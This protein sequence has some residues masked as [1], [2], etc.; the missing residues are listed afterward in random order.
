MALAGVF[1]ACTDDDL[2]G[3]SSSQSSTTGQERPAISDVTL[4]MDEAS[5]R[6]SYNGSFAFEEGDKISAL[7]MDENNTGVRY[8]STTDTDEWNALTWLERYHLVDYVH[9]NYPFIYDG[10]SFVADCN[11]LEG[12]Y[13]LVYPYTNLDGNRQA[14]IDIATQVQ[15]SGF[16]A[17]DSQGRGD[18]V[19]DN[20]Y[21]V[22][23][24]KLDAGQG[25]SD[26][27]ANLVPLLTP[28]RIAITSEGNVYTTYHITKLVFSHP[29]L[30]G[31]LTLDP[32]RA[33]YASTSGV[34][35]NLDAT[36]VNGHTESTNDVYHF[37]YA[38]FLGNQTST[39]T[40][41]DWEKELYYNANWGSTLATDYV[42]NIT[43]ETGSM[44]VARDSRDGSTYYW[45]DAIRATVQP[46]TEFNNTEYAT[47]YVEVYLDQDGAGSAA[48][49]PGGTVEAIVML[50]AFDLRNGNNTSQQDMILTIYM[51]EGIVQNINLSQ[52]YT[53][54]GT[55]LK[56][57]G[58]IDHA[59]PTDTSIQRVEFTIDN[60]AVVSSPTAVT[61]NN[62]NDLLQWLQWLNASSQNTGNKNPIATFTND[63]TIGDELA[64][65]IDLL[66]ANYV[67]TIKSGAVAGNNLR[68]ATANYPDLL[69]KLD[70]YS[71]V[72][73]EVMDGGVLNLSDTSYNIYHTYQANAADD[74]QGQLHIEVA[75]GGVLNIVGNDLNVVQGA[76][77]SSG[78]EISDRTEVFISNAG[79]LNVEEGISVVG[80]YITNE[81]EINV[82]EGASLYFTSSNGN[83]SVNTIKGFINVEGMISGTTNY[84]F[85]NFGT[86]NNGSSDGTVGGT[87]YN[88]INSSN[89]DNKIPGQIIIWSTESF[90]NLHSNTGLVDYQD[91]LA[92]VTFDTTSAD[93]TVGIYKYTG[94]DVTTSELTAA[95]V[96]DAV[97]TAGGTLTADTNYGTTLNNLT[98]Q[99]ATVTGTDTNK[100]LRFAQHTGD[101]D[102]GFSV[103]G[104]GLVT[105][106]GTC[107]A[108]D[109][110][111]MNIALQGA[112]I[113]NGANVTFSGTQVQFW[114]VYTLT[115]G[116]YDETASRAYV[117]LDA[118]SLTI[119]SGC[120]VKARGLVAVDGSH[121]DVR[122]NGTLR[123]SDGVDTTITISGSQPRL[124]E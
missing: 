119:D 21:F 61:I 51:E 103:G 89:G 11:M 56:S 78:K 64:E 5:T 73:V 31:T 36:Y 74:L 85:E 81:G 66:P 18:F 98:L 37:N 7:L 24:A 33:H 8:G 77:D 14:K 83:K 58:I 80:M 94:G 120:T 92:G 26:F 25:V 2:A 53:G 111:F 91:N 22:G 88:I 48:L 69:E 115:S 1:A 44:S 62:E 60:P 55:D 43:G 29:Q 30:T 117:C 71:N 46:M 38:N 108:Q 70:I 90:T 6:M 99:S 3:V 67:L 19:A 23:Y 93:T 68:I 118:A 112:V 65:Q 110:N 57:T 96:T 20:Q 79:T 35:W 10:S 102:A 42:Y 54:T 122:N 13:F 27:T 17:D 104:T 87:L 97:I 106:E 9:T 34:L 39:A 101:I 4:S 45:D 113:A 86:I 109:V 100:M 116:Q 63:I 28:V 50:P 75:N 107:K 52:Q 49:A 84:T 72:T 123:L 82:P 32:T 12:N 114:M 76:F 16:T 95:Y 121:S 15:T 105:F 59:D 40:A 124:G 41:A 47:Q